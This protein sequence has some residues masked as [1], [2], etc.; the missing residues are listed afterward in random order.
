M[1][2]IIHGYALGQHDSIGTMY[3]Y[4]SFAETSKKHATWIE[5]SGGDTVQIEGKD[6]KFVDDV[7]V[8]GTVTKLEFADFEHAEYG[9]IT[10]EFKAKAFSMESISWNQVIERLSSGKDRVIGTSDADYLQGYDGNDVMKGGAGDD[11]L[12]GGAGNDMLYGG[13]G[14]DVFIVGVDPHDRIYDFDANGGVGQQDFIYAEPDPLNIYKDGNN[15]VVEFE[16]GS[17]VTLIDVK[18]SDISLDD[19]A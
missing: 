4:G 6:L 17:S 9:T 1:A 15:V 13:A 18:R 14:S 10:G 12:W 7:L 3:G 19:F 5:T 8:S 2:K 11:R 16:G